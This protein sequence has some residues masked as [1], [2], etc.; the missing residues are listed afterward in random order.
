MDR[1]VGPEDVTEDVI[2]DMTDVTEAMTQLLPPEREVV[3][4]ERVLGAYI[5][6]QHGDRTVK[7]RAPVTLTG[8]G[9]GEQYMTGMCF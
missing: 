8:P 2:E 7:L 9:E 5:F 6:Q 3:P 1:I 4:P